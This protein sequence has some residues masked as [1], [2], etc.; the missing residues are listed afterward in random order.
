MDRKLPDTLPYIDR[1]KV[2]IWGW[3]YGGY[4]AGMALAKDTEGVFKCAAS[5]APVTDWT[6]Y[7]E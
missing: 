4:A 2:A 1:E 5:V 3:S 6:Y 7:G